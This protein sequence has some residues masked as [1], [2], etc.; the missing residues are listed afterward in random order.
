MEEMDWL[1]RRDGWE[2][3][4]EA[5]RARNGRRPRKRRVKRLEYKDPRLA[6]RRGRG[7]RT[8]AAAADDRRARLNLSLSALAQRLSLM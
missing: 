2:G 5:I 3:G 8:A 7:T 1:V 6:R 4:L